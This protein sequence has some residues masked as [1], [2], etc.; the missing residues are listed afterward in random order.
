MG[1]E[2]RGNNQYYYKKE[3]DGARVRSVYVGNGEIAHMISTIQSTSPLLERLARSKKS[4]ETVEPEK[5]EDLMDQ[6]SDRICLVTQ[7]T[8][9]VTGLRPAYWTDV[10]FN[11]K[12][13]PSD[14]R[15]GVELKKSNI[16]GRA[17]IADDWWTGFSGVELLPPNF[18][19]EH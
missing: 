2:R 19:V 18:K 11:R 7:A 16:T 12:T 4:S 10:R 6:L 5:V 1:W 17:F 13:Y 9:L 15:E 14:P 3:R 8:L